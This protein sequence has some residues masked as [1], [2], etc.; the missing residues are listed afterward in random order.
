MREEGQSDTG[1]GKI[2]DRQGMLTLPSLNYRKYAKKFF[3]FA[4][5]G[6]PVFIQTQADILQTTCV[7]LYGNRSVT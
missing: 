5:K 6:W 4:P 2:K 1:E 7:K 3:L